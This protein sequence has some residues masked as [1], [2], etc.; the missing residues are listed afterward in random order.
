MFSY[1]FSTATSTYSVTAIHIRLL[2]A[3]SEVTKSDL[4][5]RCCLIHLK[6]SSICHR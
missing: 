6:K 4:K 3:F 1:F 5:R 2:T